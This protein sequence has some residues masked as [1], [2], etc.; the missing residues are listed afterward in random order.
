[1]ADVLIGIGT[2]SAW[3]DTNT[4]PWSIR[5]LRRWSDFQLI[6]LIDAVFPKVHNQPE[7]VQRKLLAD[8]LFDQSS[9]TPA[10][11]HLATMLIQHRERHEQMNSYGKMHVL[12]VFLRLGRTRPIAHLL[13]R[14]DIK[15]L[16]A[17]LADAIRWNHEHSYEGESL[18]FMTS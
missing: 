5:R 11:L 9:L 3:S 18:S 10:G 2:L 14:K 4:I 12:K 1:M 7:H 8:Q 13:K 16:P 17:L 15:Y 6:K